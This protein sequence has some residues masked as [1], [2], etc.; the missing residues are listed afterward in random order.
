MM[1]ADSSMNMQW[2][3]TL[4]AFL[5]NVMPAVLVTV[6]PHLQSG[7]HLMGGGESDVETQFPRKLLTFL[8]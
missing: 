1:T 4:L 7:F 2:S 8:Y 3:Q 5:C 6:H